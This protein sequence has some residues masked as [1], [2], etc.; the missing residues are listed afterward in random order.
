MQASV[1]YTPLRGAMGKQEAHRPVGWLL[2]DGLCARAPDRQSRHYRKVWIVGSK[3]C[4]CKGLH[5]G[6]GERIVGQQ[7]MGC[8]EV[9][10]GSEVGKGDRF[11]NHVKGGDLISS[12]FVMGELL[13]DGRMFLQ[14]PDGRT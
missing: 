14:L 12:D 3:V 2:A 10:S 5:D 4:E 7:T 6:G 13:D 8:R 9:L 11:Y 1:L